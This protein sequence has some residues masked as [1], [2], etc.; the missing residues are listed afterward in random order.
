MRPVLESLF[1]RMLLYSPPQ[2]RLDALKAV[3]EV[4]IHIGLVHNSIECKKSFIITKDFLLS[5][6]TEN[7]TQYVQLGSTSE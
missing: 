6:V 5:A 2:H 7:S 4:S 1:H 3:R